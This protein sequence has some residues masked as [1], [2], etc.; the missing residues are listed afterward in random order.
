LG[1]GLKNASPPSLRKGGKV[2]GIY[3]FIIMFGGLLIRLG[4]PILVTV[5]ITIWLR[6]LD[7]KWKREAEQASLSA[8]RQRRVK[9]ANCWELNNCAP[10]KRVNCP[11]FAKPQ[12]PCWTQ[13]TEA[14]G[15]IRKSC[16][17]CHVYQTAPVVVIS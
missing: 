4:I 8:A 13:F 15:Q 3:S 1:L 9:G 2:D 10:A 14:N 6:R 17:G 5:L 11:A 7:E 16:E 12:I